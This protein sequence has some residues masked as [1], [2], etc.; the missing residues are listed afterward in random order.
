MEINE[1]EGVIKNNEKSWLSEVFNVAQHVQ[2]ITH[3]QLVCPFIVHI[4][5]SDMRLGSAWRRKKYDNEKKNQRRRGY[6]KREFYE[7]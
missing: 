6:G 2:P 3:T 1:K 5:A 4:E 7:K